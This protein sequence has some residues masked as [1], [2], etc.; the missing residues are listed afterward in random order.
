MS[1]GSLILDSEIRGLLDENILGGNVVYNDANYD[2][3]D[4]NLTYD[5]IPTRVAIAT[6]SL[7]SLTAFANSTV[8]ISV[9][10]ESDL[11]GLSASSTSNVTKLVSAASEFG[12]LSSE[13]ISLVEHIS[14]ASADF[15]ELDAF[16]VPLTTR[17]VSADAQLGAIE[18]NA[19][20]DVDNIVAASAQLGSL[21][22][23]AISI[24]ESQNSANADLGE[25]TAQAISQVIPPTPPPSPSIGNGRADY[26]VPRLKKKIKPE[27]IKTEV[28][29]VKKT[30]PARPV[31]KTVTASADTLAGI[32]SATSQSQI[33]FS[34]LEDEAELLLL[35]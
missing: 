32:F 20:S 4:P 34:I 18:A 15:G 17:F 30:E 6:S 13:V 7:G 28:P 23:Q 22:A 5:G 25:L 24:I 19:N 16:A 8:S 11:D 21:T 31:F 3:S 26:S 29:V 33:D 27:V 12:D 14:T 35:I 1:A 10:A 2:Y 9:L